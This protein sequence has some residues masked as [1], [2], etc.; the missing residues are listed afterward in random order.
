MRKIINF[1]FVVSVFAG[2]GISVYVGVSMIA[3]VQ[4]KKISLDHLPNADAIVCLAGAKGR[5][6]SAATF[7]NEYQLRGRQAPKLVIA[8]MG[9]NANW[10]VF[11]NQLGPELQSKIRSDQVLLEMQSQ[12]TVQNAQEMLKF[13]QQFQ[14]KS[15]VLMTSFYHLQRAEYIFKE[16]F[17][18]AGVQVEIIPNGITSESLDGLENFK[19]HVIETVKEIYYRGFWS[20]GEEPMV[21]LESNPEP[22]SAK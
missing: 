7:W 17:K 11:M 9:K 21:S 22:S 10:S 16:V 12:N 20:P 5:I 18:H 13:A 6:H 14:W 4:L 8:G 3:N 2:L 19:Q 1:L 15:I